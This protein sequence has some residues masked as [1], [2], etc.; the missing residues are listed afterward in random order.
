MLSGG[1]NH[2]RDTALSESNNQ[3]ATAYEE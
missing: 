3:E 2:G 1:M